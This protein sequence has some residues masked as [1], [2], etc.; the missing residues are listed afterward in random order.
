M[1]NAGLD[2]ETPA[3]RLAIRKVLIG[4]VPARAVTPAM[5]TSGVE[6]VTS[7][8]DDIRVDI[9]R[10]EDYLA[11]LLRGIVIGSMCAPSEKPCVPA[12]VLPPSLASRMGIHNVAVEAVT[13]G[14]AAASIAADVTPE[15]KPEEG[16]AAPAPAAS[17]EPAASGTAAVEEDDVDA[18]FATAK[19]KKKSKAAA[20]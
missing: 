11:E 1:L 20:Q 15:A 9:P 4:L 13:S 3:E 8:L 19:K 14:L 17:S 2:S 7:Q 18:L 16:A 10:A 5:L 6:A 12:S